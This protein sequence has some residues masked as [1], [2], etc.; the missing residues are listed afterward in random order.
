[1][2]IHQP[3][4]IKT[5]V[6]DADEHCVSPPDIKDEES[7]KEECQETEENPATVSCDE[8]TPPGS[9]DVMNSVPDCSINQSFAEFQLSLPQ[10]LEL[11]RKT[12]VLP[13]SRPCHDLF[14]EEKV[15]FRKDG[16]RRASSKPRKELTL[17]EKVELINKSAGRSQRSLA[18]EYQIAKTQ[19][20]NIMKRKV[21]IILANEENRDINRKR[22]YNYNKNADINQLTWLWYQEAC[23]LG[24]TVNGPMLQ[25]RALYFASSLGRNDFKASNGWLNR[26]KIRHNIAIPR[27]NTSEQNSQGKN[28]ETVPESSES[29][30]SMNMPPFDGWTI[31]T[32]PQDVDE[33]NSMDHE[34]EASKPYPDHNIES[35][36]EAIELTN[37][38]KSFCLEKNLNMEGLL[39]FSAVLESAAVL[40]HGLYLNQAQD[41]QLLPGFQDNK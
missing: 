31:K 6:E 39:S 16:T 28:A 30:D 26:F 34:E 10:K 25:E 13:L 5:E 24:E 18:R 41:N 38:L 21:E 35:F 17:A 32:E 2:S 22:I 33:S 9:A 37:Q 36:E 23:D 12:P 11:I 4:N 3:T 20:Q 7:H 40:N 27:T 1:M 14:L 15:Q 8:V 29:A 19:V